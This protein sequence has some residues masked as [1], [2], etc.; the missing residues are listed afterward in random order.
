MADLHQ[1]EEIGGFTLFTEDVAR[2]ELT[3]ARRRQKIALFV[4]GKTREQEW[5]FH[6]FCRHSPT[7]NDGE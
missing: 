1:R 5:R 6:A 4:V 7:G 3:W 2:L